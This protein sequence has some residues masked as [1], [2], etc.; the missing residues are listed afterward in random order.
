MRDMSS[1]DEYIHLTCT[2]LEHINHGNAQLLVI[3]ELHQRDI[4]KRRFSVD[5]TL[6]HEVLCILADISQQSICA[7]EMVVVMDGMTKLV[8]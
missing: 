1:Q 4:S 3:H 2:E 8:Q 7:R 5:M 6:I